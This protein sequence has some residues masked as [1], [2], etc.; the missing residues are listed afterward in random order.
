[1]LQRGPNFLPGRLKLQ[2]LSLV[3]TAAMTFS[4]VCLFIGPNIVF[5]HLQGSASRWATSIHSNI[6]VRGI[7]PAGSLLPEPT[8]TPQT[9]QYTIDAVLTPASHLITGHEV[10]QIPD[11]P[12]QELHFYLFSAS[13]LTNPIQI[14]DVQM[15]LHS[16]PFRVANGELIIP[17][18]KKGNPISLDITF[19][20]SVPAAP[21]RLGEFSGVWSLDYWYP[22]LA[23][24][25]DNKWIGRPVPQNFGDPF[26]MDLASYTIHF[27]APAGVH[28][29][30]SA[31]P[32]ETKSLASG[33]NLTTWGP[34]LLRNFALF[35]SSSF[36]E[37]TFQ[38]NPETSVQVVGQE[39]SDIDQLFNLT[40]QTTHFYQTAFGALTTKVITVIVMPSQT[41]YAHEYPNL[42][43]LSR[44]T[45]SW[46]TSSH[47][48]THE[49]AH[50]WWFT[51]VGT[52]KALHPWLDEGLAEY[53]SLLAEEA[54]DG[55]PAYQSTIKQDWTLFSTSKSYSPHSSGAPIEAGG[56]TMDT[57]YSSFS[58][59][60]TYYQIEYLRALLMYAD[61]RQSM[62]DTAF[63]AFLK[64]FYNKNQQKTATPESLMQAMHDVSPANEQLLKMWIE[65]PNAVLIDTVTSRFQ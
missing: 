30:A 21:T 60:A 36:Q 62:G 3:L 42:A 54:I 37:R 47:W 2:L 51:E 48:I 50:A 23:V 56:L 14:Q 28:W 44:D 45:L 4:I 65:T 27:R 49:I 55:K 40:Q 9:P 53:S 16:V 12:D 25:S 6:P 63:F 7:L 64:D 10:C 1:M 43:L 38:L 18:L 15:N 32:N 8:S 5:Q 57:P 31:V 29:Y 52:Y 22:I 19:S 11:L 46:P 33:E 61:L 59:D 41:V 13:T 20:T 34:S 58:D 24:R 39:K 35:G 26:L 17:N